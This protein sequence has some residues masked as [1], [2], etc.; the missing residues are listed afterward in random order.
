MVL[1]LLALLLAEASGIPSGSSIVGTEAYMR[2]AGY[3]FKSNQHGVAV[4]SVT[5]FHLISPNRTE[6]IVTEAEKD[7]WFALKVCLMI[8]T[9]RGAMSSLLTYTTGRIQQLRE[10][11][12]FIENAAKS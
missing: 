10:L 3:S 11:P 12:E 2:V 9:K 6:I 1:A 5:G 8:T 7:L 4:D